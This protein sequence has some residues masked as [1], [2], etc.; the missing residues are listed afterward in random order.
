MPAYVVSRVQDLLNDRASS[1]CAARPCCCSASRTSPTSPT[2]ARAPRCRSPSS[3]AR[4]GADVTYHD[5]YV[6]TWSPGAPGEEA[7]RSEADPVAAARGA[8]VVV[9][10]Q[11]HRGLDLDALA[12]AAPALLDTRGAVAEGGAVTRL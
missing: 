12:Q 10:L 4:R 6:A 9:V 3:C 11:A 2:S 1:R 5:P 7:L 8:D